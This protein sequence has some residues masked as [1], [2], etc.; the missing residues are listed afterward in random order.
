MRE[1]IEGYRK[2]ATARILM[3]TSRGGWEGTHTDFKRELGSK[4]RDYSKLVK[5]LLA[6]A[7]TP[8]RAEAFIIFGFEENQSKNRFDHVGV[9]ENSLPSQETIEQIVESYTKLQGVV[10][11]ELFTFDGKRTP[12]IVIPMQYEGPYSVTQEG[13]KSIAP[14]QIFTR[15]GSRSVLAMPRDIARMRADW[16]AWFLDGRYEK[17][18]ASLLS[19]LAKRF[20]NN[21]RLEDMGAY[22]RL[23]YSS[24]VS[25]EF[26]TNEAFVLVHAYWGL[27]PVDAAAVQTIVGDNQHPFVRRTIIGAR[28]TSGL[29]ALAETVG[30]RC[31]VLD[32]IYFVNDSYAKL[33]RAYLQQ[34]EKERSSRHL[35]S[36]V[37]LD[38][39][40]Y[41]QRSELPAR[42]SIVSFLEDQLR[43]GGKAAILVHGDFGCGKTTT[44][45]LLVAELCEEYLRGNV[46]VPKVLYLNVNNIDI[47]ARRDECIESELRR[48]DM[49]SEIIREL[50]Q[51]VLRDEIQMIFDGVDEMARPYTETGR[52]DAIELLRDIGNRRT[53]IYLV[54]SSYYPE[55]QGMISSFQK[56][57]D[58]DFK[59]KENRT[60]VIQVTALREEQVIE[61]L[62]SRIGKENGSVVRSALHKLGLESFLSDPLI[63]SLVCNL[64][65]EQGLVSIELFPREG[66]KARFLGYLVDELLKREQEKRQRHGGLA[67]DFKQFQQV[68]QTV[69]FMMIC[70]G[71]QAI[72][73]SQLRAFVNRAFENETD[74][75]SEAVDAFRTM[76]WIHPSAEGELAFRHEALTLVCAAHY[77]NRCLEHRNS[78]E[79]GDWQP[80]APLAEVVCQFA[81][82]I[83]PSMGILG[84][85]EM[86]ASKLQFNVRHLIAGVLASAELRDNVDAVQDDALPER[87]LASVLRGIVS[88]LGLTRLSI[89]ILM[90]SL[91][92]KR[93]LQVTVILLWFISRSNL[94]ESV[95]PSAIDLL[96]PRVKRDRNFCDDLRTLKENPGT[97]FDAMLLKDLGII[98]RD[99]MDMTQYEKL[100]DKIYNSDRIDTPTKQ[101]AERTLRGI[102]GEKR[103]LAQFRDSRGLGQ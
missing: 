6:F 94:N 83:I 54:R 38:Y 51:R 36:I 45:K 3:A 8:R 99:L 24:R 30:V 50:V 67:E 17:N 95:L 16:T 89:I 58:Y 4:Q 84:A 52:D 55:L 102:E 14:G 56:L 42:P 68:L 98:T 69:A 74:Q 12:Y 70:K 19:T 20:T 62:D 60:V 103:R 72:A 27:E 9:T 31:V 85:T 21:S 77:V 71:S 46:S 37:D 40:S 32:E 87:T 73:P 79:L 82:E 53:A 63:V 57:A 78:I 76:A 43:L 75:N 44:A 35:S 28:F 97:S 48:Y 64:I 61:Y 80:Q 93:M 41:N 1:P 49:P 66:H 25:D 96:H 65:E 11:D 91:S 26:G 59:A 5:H 13:L 33:C 7:N 92:E 86:L 23:T 81:G 2:E 18:A 90:K 47:R 100:F 29:I 101:F 15:Y 88:D 39:R 34:W 22:V 10:V